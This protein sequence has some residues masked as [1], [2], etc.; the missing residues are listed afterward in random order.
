MV[1]H[2]PET[3]FGTGETDVNNIREIFLSA[4]TLLS[5]VKLNCKM[6]YFHRISNLQLKKCI[7]KEERVRHLPGYCP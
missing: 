5:V 6:S 7:K 1:L 2:Q 4:Q 3:N